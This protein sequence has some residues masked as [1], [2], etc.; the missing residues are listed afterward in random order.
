MAAAAILHLA[1][2][3]RKEEARAL[4][5]KFEEANQAAKSASDA[6]GRAVAQQAASTL[7]AKLTEV[8]GGQEQVLELISVIT[9]GAPRAPAATAAASSSAATAAASSSAA[10]TAGAAGAAKAAA[11]AAARAAARASATARGGASGSP[12]ADAEEGEIPEE[13]RQPAHGG[14]RSGHAAGGSSLAPGRLELVLDLDHT[15]VHAVELTSA[16]ELEARPPAGVHTFPLHRV[17]PHG[18]GVFQTNY[19]LRVRDGVRAF[20]REVRR[21]C[22]VHVYTMGSQSYAKQVIGLIDPHETD[23]DGTILCRR[24]D[25]DELFTK[26]ISHLIPGEDV[27]AARRRQAMIILDDREDAWDVL[28]RSS[29]LQIPQF[30]CWHDDSTPMAPRS[31]EPD[32]TLL[33]MLGVLKAVSADL[34]SGAQPSVPAAL[35]QRR[36][37][38]LAGCVLIFSGGLLR[39]A[40]HPER[41]VPWRMAEVCGAR[42]EISFLEHVTHVVSPNPD[43]GS[44]KRAAQRGKHAVSLHWLLDSVARWHRQDEARYSLIHPP[45]NP[46][47]PTPSERSSAAARAEEAYRL[48]MQLMPAADEAMAKVAILYLAPTERKEEARALLR[49]FEEAN[50][51]AK[52]ASDGAGR[53]AAQQAVSTLL[54]KLTEMV[55]GQEQMLE[56]IS[57]VTTGAARVV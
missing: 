38:I 46:P 33:D 48:V 51:A 10:A 54:A 8:V 55:G 30:R 13:R 37:G 32:A 27:E 25:D 56:L 44:V 6:A 29:V 15:L 7:I 28:S 17:N 47:L 39:D 9:T 53:A 22:T 5:R 34:A 36:R 24:D 21:F 50:Q 12:H 20:L 16:S 57:F 1:P 11:A 18:P 2:T 19:K 40:A 23:I 52:S 31:S 35:H 49:K 26:S 4:L 42:C 14:R 43:T 45:P 3:E 41:C